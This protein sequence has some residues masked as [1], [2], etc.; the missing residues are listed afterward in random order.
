MLDL[1]MLVWSMLVLSMAPVCRAC[2]DAPQAGKV[3]TNKENK[4]TKC[5]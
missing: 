4:K 5:F 1:S 3:T 2:I